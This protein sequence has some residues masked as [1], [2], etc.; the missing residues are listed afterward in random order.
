MSQAFHAEN[1]TRVRMVRTLCVI[2]LSKLENNSLFYYNSIQ[3]GNF[4]Y[5]K[6]YKNVDLKIFFS[7]LPFP[8]THTAANSQRNQQ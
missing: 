7:P 2:K 3:T 5:F 6:Y 4:K 1:N 8:H